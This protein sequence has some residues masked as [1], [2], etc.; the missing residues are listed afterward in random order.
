VT[1]G[2]NNGVSVLDNYS[3]MFRRRAGVSEAGSSTSA[4]HQHQPS[5]TTTA[6]PYITR[7]F[8]F[9]R[10]HTPRATIMADSM[11][12]VVVEGEQPKTENVEHKA[13]AGK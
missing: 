6:S 5:P 12:G 3:P 4:K 10:I 2:V 13:I 9:L 11:E 8:R 1:R 7:T